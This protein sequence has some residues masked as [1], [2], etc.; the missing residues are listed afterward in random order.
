[1]RRWVKRRG[2]AARVDCSK[3]CTGSAV[4]VSAVL[5]DKPDANK[6]LEKKSC[7]IECALH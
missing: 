2:V 3:N 1:M 5:K 7:I 4:V 6:M